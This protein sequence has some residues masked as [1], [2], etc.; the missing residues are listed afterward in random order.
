MKNIQTAHTKVFR[1]EKTTRNRDDFKV[2]VSGSLIMILMLLTFPLIGRVYDSTLATRPFVTATVEVVQTDD[3]KLPMI[4]Y[5]ADAT[6]LVTARWI[7]I[8]RDGDDS[9]LGTRRG[10]SDYSAKEDNPRLWTWEAFF[11]D[12]TGIAAPPVP[13]QPFKVCIMYI[14]TTVDTGISDET[15]E[16]CSKVFYPELADDAVME[17]VR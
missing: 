17:S 1:A 10:E 15:P 11:N 3:Y 16:T 14:S 6:Q 9:R 8:V 7:R 13:T 4:L 12:G 5:D 2:L